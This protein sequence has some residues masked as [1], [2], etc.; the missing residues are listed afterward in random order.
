[1]SDLPDELKRAGQWTLALD[2]V[3]KAEIEPRIKRMRAL[4]YGFVQGESAIQLAAIFYVGIPA[5]SQAAPLF[6]EVADQKFPVVIRPPFKDINEHA[7]VS[8]SHGK[9]TC[10][11]CLGSEY[12][13]LTAAHV[14]AG[15]DDELKYSLRANDTVRCSKETLSSPCE[16]RILAID[17]V[18]DAALVTAEVGSK[19]K[20][21]QAMEYVGFFPIR[22]ETPGGPLDSMIIEQEV[23]KGSFQEAPGRGLLTRHCF[24]VPPRVFQ[25]G[26]EVWFR[27]GER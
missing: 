12:G 21:V 22:I 4:T 11:A 10:H 1:M 24:S 23:H 25:V 7:D 14:V 15:R 18:M 2:A 6:V 19:P 8:F 3:V 17:P 9:V 13:V 16:H 20:A 5:L 26:L 27:E